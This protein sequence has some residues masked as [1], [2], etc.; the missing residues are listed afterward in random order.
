[1]LLR[2]VRQRGTLPRSRAVRATRLTLSP[3]ASAHARVTDSLRRVSRGS[4]QV[5]LIRTIV[6]LARGQS[7]CC[8]C[9]SEIFMSP[10]RT[11]GDRR[12]SIV[13]AWGAVAICLVTTS[14]LLDRTG[15]EPR[16]RGPTLPSSIAFRR[17]IVFAYRLRP[18]V[19]SAARLGLAAIAGL[20]VSKPET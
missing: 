5:L 4:T 8:F 11:I 12:R 13:R 20:L 10:T 1:M 18:G 2:A 3:L 9:L 19:L 17:P 16:P 15:D 6:E 14:T 7:R